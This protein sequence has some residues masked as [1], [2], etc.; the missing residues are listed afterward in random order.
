MFAGN[1]VL[2]KDKFEYLELQYGNSIKATKN[3][4]IAALKGN[5]GKLTV[6]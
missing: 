4:V 2:Q 6:C 5:C 1:T 3:L